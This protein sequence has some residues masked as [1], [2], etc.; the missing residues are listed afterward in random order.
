VTGGIKEPK[1]K[2]SGSKSIEG[3]DLVFGSAELV[4]G[5]AGQGTGGVIKF[6]SQIKGDEV[7][8]LENQGINLQKRKVKLVHEGKETE[9]KAVENGGRSLEKTWG[10]GF[11]VRGKNYGFYRVPS[12][13]NFDS[14]LRRVGEF[15]ACPHSFQRK[16]V[17]VGGVVFEEGLKEKVRVAKG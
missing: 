15:P 11:R 4:I 1:F 9:E 3:G 12:R 13:L 5:K 14:S 2:A 16:V 6:T 10:S 7:V 17:F 8:F